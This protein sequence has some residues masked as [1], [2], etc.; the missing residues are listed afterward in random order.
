MEGVVRLLEDLH[1]DPGSRTVLLF[2][3]K[4]QA[5]TQCEF[6]HQ[7][8]VTGMTEL[9]LVKESSYSLKKASVDGAV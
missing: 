1:L 3:W 6:T 8:F 5:A 7:E 9:G 2:A 4:L